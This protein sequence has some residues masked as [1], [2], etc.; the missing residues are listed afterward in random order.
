MISLI[1]CLLSDPRC[2]PQRAH[3]FDAGADLVACTDVIVRPGQ[4]HLLDTGV[5]VKIPAGYAGFVLNRSSQRVRG[6]TSLGTGLI[7][8]EYRGTIKVF[9]ENTGESEYVVKAYETKIA[10]L[11][12][13][14]V[15]L[16][17]FY[18]VEDASNWLD[19]ER[20]VNGFGSTGG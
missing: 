10:Q 19:T 4:K 5:A 9:L 14:P 18:P 2:V 1:D 6:I 12:V 11:V 13:M 17:D 16:C 3:D 15:V 8:S 7:D 20:G